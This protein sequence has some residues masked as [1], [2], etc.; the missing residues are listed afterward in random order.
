M[1]ITEDLEEALIKLTFERCL[2]T[3]TYVRTDDRLF[4]DKIIFSL[5]DKKE[6]KTNVKNTN[7][8]KVDLQGFDSRDRNNGIVMNE[9]VDGLNYNRN[10]LAVLHG[11]VAGNERENVS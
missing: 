1:V 5:S 2:K 7:V 9:M 10:M 6:E 8:N 3:F 11:H 4:W